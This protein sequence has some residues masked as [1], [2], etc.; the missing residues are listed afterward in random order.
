MTGL[1]VGS[2]DPQL[3]IVPPCFFY[4]PSDRCV[5]HLPIIG[6][7]Q[8]FIFAIGRDLRPHWQVENAKHFI[9]PLGNLSGWII[10]PTA[11]PGRCLGPAQCLR[12]LP[13]HLFLFPAI[14][15]ID[16]RAQHPDKPAFL[17][18]HQRGR[19]QYPAIRS[20]PMPEPVFVFISR[21]GIF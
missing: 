6:M 4:G 20:V 7:K 9:G 16:M 13:Q 14:G 21:A 10:P 3:Q 18:I 11:D 8:I 15:N 19:R 5:K 17:V 1:P 12:T 2:D